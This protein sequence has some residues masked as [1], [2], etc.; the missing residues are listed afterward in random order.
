MKENGSQMKT[1][2]QN[3]I[4]LMLGSV[5]A[6]MITAI[7]SIILT[8][9]YTVE[10][11]GVWSVFLSMIS[12]VSCII[13]LRY[14]NAIVISEKES[15]AVNTLFLSIFVLMVNCILIAIVFYIFRDELVH[16]WLKQ[17]IQ[18]VTF[19]IPVCLF[20]T[21]IFQIFNYWCIR[22]SFF[23]SVA[24]RNIVNAVLSGVFEIAFGVLLIWGQKG[25]VIGSV[26][27]TVGSGLLIAFCSIYG[28][29]NN[30]K[31][32]FLFTSVFKCA[33]KYR[34]FPLF[35]T[36]SVLLNQ[37]STTIATFFLVSYF[38]EMVVGYYSIAQQIIMLPIVFIGTAIGQ[39]LYASSVEATRDN[40][41]SIFVERI[42][43]LLI[44]IGVIPILLI[45]I[46]APQL[47]ELVYG[48][49]WSTAG[50]YIRLLTPWIVVVFI[51][52]PLTVI[53]DTLGKQKQYLVFNIVLFG[54]R[55]IALIIGGTVNN[56]IL[57]LSLYSFVGAFHFLIVGIYVLKIC[58]CNILNTIKGGIILIIPQILKYLILPIIICLISSSI[59]VNVSI[60][61][62]FGVLFL[63]FDGKKMYIDIKKG[64]N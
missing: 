36:W 43:K 8:R 41:L 59:I 21:G 1:F 50:I 7:V 26:L 23:I 33:L 24:L 45:F 44:S 38:G 46:C 28:S 49:G 56:I 18:E 12:V 3:T 16:F 34:K 2:A 32:N 40:M 48:D 42:V 19:L 27:G 63:I 10:A 22:H 60:C 6:Q 13:S 61:V 52:S 29:W 9:L 58:K 55:V 35:S 39:V 47:C 15:E 54:L 11:I 64:V 62:C 57:T 30:I 53:F 25:V 20:G 5:A 17:G 31:E 37:I 14:E 51:V 4:V